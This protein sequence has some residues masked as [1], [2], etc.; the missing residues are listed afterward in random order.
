M[1]A[2]FECKYRRYNIQSNVI[3]IEFHN[4]VGNIDAVVFRFQ[5]YFLKILEN[6]FV[7]R[8]AVVETCTAMPKDSVVMIL[9]RH[10]RSLRFDPSLLL[11]ENKG[12]TDTLSASKSK[13]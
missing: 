2:L 9:D 10:C 6:H 11:P 8:D 3:H 1:Q 13:V 7:P 12:D 4:L 5:K